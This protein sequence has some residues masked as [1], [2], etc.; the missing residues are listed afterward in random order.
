V[1]I[2][3]VV[4]LLVVAGVFLVLSRFVF[5]QEEDVVE[6][7]NGQE[8]TI[9][10]EALAFPL[11][12]FVIEELSSQA[13]REFDFAFSKAREWREDSVFYG[14]LVNYKDQI[15]REKGNNTYIFSSPSLPEFYWTLNIEQA[16][17]EIGEHNF[18]RIIYYKEDYFL[19]NN[20]VAVPMQYWE[21]DYMG[22]LQ[23]A[24]NLGGKDIRST[25]GEYDVNVLLSVEEGSYL[26][27]DV[28]YVVGGK[29]IYSLSLNAYNGE[30]S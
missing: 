22:A 10:E 17:N 24:D 19:S 6:T 12:E 30:I 21:W 18:E 20:A 16:K 28:E 26:L 8:E 15:A 25:Y 13:E 2:I 11:S 14:L 4:V 29:S 7:E 1:I 5:Q 9:E 27:W 3:A 23:K